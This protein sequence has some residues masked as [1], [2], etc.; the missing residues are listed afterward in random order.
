MAP[1]PLT[2]ATRRSPAGASP[3]AKRLQGIPRSPEEQV[4]QETLEDHAA[5]IDQHRGFIQTLA[6]RV[7][8]MIDL[9]GATQKRADEKDQEFMGKL[10]KLEEQVVSTTTKANASEARLAT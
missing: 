10:Q 3:P 7:Q 1:D 6:D 2:P 4:V 9:H 8:N 5:K